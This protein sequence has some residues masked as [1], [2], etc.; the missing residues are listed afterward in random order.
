MRKEVDGL[1][2]Y[3][4][5]IGYSQLTPEQYREKILAIDEMKKKQDQ[6]RK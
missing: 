1:K 5:H 6:A 3:L 2:N 4:N